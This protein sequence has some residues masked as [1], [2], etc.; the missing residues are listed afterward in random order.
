MAVAT[1]KTQSIVNRRQEYHPH[2]I[3]GRTAPGQYIKLVEALQRCSG[4]VH[5]PCQLHRFTTLVHSFIDAVTRFTTSNRVF[6]GVKMRRPPPYYIHGSWPPCEDQFRSKTPASTRLLSIPPYAEQRWPVVFSADMIDGCSLL[7]TTVLCVQLTRW[8][9]TIVQDVKNAG[10]EKD[11]VLN[12]SVLNLTL[13]ERIY[14]VMQ[15]CD[16][17]TEWQIG[18]RGAFAQLDG[19]LYQYHDLMSRIAKRVD[20][21]RNRFR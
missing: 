2:H 21:K 11:L 7:Q 14:D 12:E 13:L 3:C 17:E 8:L 5:Y 18:A 1:A 19:P 4:D 9:I 16:P 6:L 20:P 15:T 10:K